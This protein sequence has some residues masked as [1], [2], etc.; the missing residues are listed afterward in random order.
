MKRIVGK[1]TAGFLAVSLLVAGAG[2]ALAYRSRLQQ[3]PERTPEVRSLFQGITYERKV[4][5]YPR[6]LVA[7]IITVD[8]TAPGIDFLVTPSSPNDKNLEFAADTVPGFAS[9]HNVQVAINGSYFF[10][11]HARLPFFYYPR[12]G[13]G[14]DA[15][16]LSIS[17]AQKESESEEGWA[18][19]CILSVRDI[20][21]T[22]QDCPAQTQQGL[23][24][25]IQFVKEG[26]F[27]D[28]GLDLLKNSVKLMPRSAIAINKD[29][30]KLWLILIDGRQGSYSGGVT[31]KELAKIAVDLGADR[32]IN[33]DGGGSSA[34]AV[35]Q[36][37]SPAILNAPIQARV[38]MT[39][40]PVAN[41]LGIYAQPLITS[42]RDKSR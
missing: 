19:L 7:H 3:R 25:D 6:S 36:A 8:L 17:N 30:S 21:I 41:H 23:A 16:G 32:A 29:T 38:P 10:P 40:R 34:L 22:S 15:Q 35:E 31:L 2:L 9:R 42:E 1:R 26:A 13:N 39:L 14:V 24:G 11:Q 37:G 18:A 20:Q 33:L 28:K 27:Y 5:N 4:P 12:I